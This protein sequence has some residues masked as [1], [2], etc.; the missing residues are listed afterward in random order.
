MMKMFQST[1]PRGARLCAA[2]V[3]LKIDGVSIHTP[4]W[5]ATKFPGLELKVEKFQST[6]PR[7]ARRRHPLGSGNMGGF[8]PHA[9]VG[10]DK[11]DRVD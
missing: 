5:G 1:R 9:R 7:G 10:R 8:N 11:E 3:I 4:A 6:R 2:S